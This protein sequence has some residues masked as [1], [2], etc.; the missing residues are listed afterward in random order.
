MVPDGINFYS[1]TVGIEAPSWYFRSHW[2]CPSRFALRN[3]TIGGSVSQ[4]ELE[5][6]GNEC[7]QKALSTLEWNEFSNVNISILLSS[8]EDVGVASITIEALANP[9]EVRPNMTIGQE[10]F[11][12]PVESFKDC[13]VN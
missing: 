11:D 2:R 5:S 3:D 9:H 4:T 7:S 6:Q 10:Q 12:S 1:S 8:V 13:I